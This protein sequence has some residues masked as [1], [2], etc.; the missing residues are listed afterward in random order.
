[1]I[2]PLQYQTLHSCLK[3]YWVLCRLV[4]LLKTSRFYFICFVLW[5]E[6]WASTPPQLWVSVWLEY[7]FLGWMAPLRHIARLS[8]SFDLDLSSFC[9]PRSVQW[10][11]WCNRLRVRDGFWLKQRAGYLNGR[12]ILISS[13][14]VVLPCYYYKHFPNLSTC[15]NSENHFT[16]L[17]KHFSK[18][19]TVT[20]GHKCAQLTSKIRLWTL[21]PSPLY[22]P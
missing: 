4:L 22:Y 11:L 7:F 16:A 2:F 10:M 18:F 3:R 20:V 14:T 13:S 15:E 1:M 5:I 8:N 21:R 17:M 12:F 9:S 6:R 19:R